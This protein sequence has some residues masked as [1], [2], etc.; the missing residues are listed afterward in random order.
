MRMV[1]ALLMLPLPAAADSV[2][3]ARTIR[4]LS[5]LGPEDVTLVAAALPGAL[6]DPREALGLEAR[7]TLYAGRAIRAADLG[8]P[9]LIE[10]N[11]VVPLIFRAGGLTIAAEGRALGR[12]G[13]G[14]AVRA[15][16]LA[17]RSVV[18]GRVGPDGAVW[19]GDSP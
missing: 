11:Q 14:D 19:V 12:G 16:N 4:A 10:R 6:T 2:I 15:M 17:S 13:A 18:T 3:A 7:V 1:L 8:P 9:A 5:L